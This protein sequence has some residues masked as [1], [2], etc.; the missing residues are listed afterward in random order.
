MISIFRAFSLRPAKIEQS[1][2]GDPPDLN[3]PAEAGMFSHP[4]NSRAC[5]YAFG[6]LSVQGVKIKEIIRA[7]T[8]WS[9][10]VQM[11][12]SPRL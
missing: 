6:H 7:A 10:I 9:G 3:D 1:S 2:I 4:V 8:A 5:F 11:E 12:A